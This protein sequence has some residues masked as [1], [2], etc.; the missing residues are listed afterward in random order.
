MSLKGRWWLFSYLPII[1]WFQQCHQ[2]NPEAL[3]PCYMNII[4]AQISGHLSVH[5][6]F[7]ANNKKK[8][9]CALL[10]V[11]ALHCS[12][13][14]FF[15]FLFTI[16]SCFHAMITLYIYKKMYHGKYSFLVIFFNVKSYVN[17]CILLISIISG[18]LRHRVVASCISSPCLFLVHI[19]IVVSSTV[20]SCSH[21]W[22][23]SQV[24]NMY[25]RQHIAWEKTSS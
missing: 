13:A 24:P 7:W 8:Q 5:S 9:R 3:Q 21:Y 16:F 14:V 2:K 4:V 12:F 20:E 19:F 10:P 22:F 11:G 17:F 18:M 6:Q 25:W 15:Q 23:I 1:K